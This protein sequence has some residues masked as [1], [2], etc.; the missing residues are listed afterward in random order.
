MPLYN[1]AKRHRRDWAGGTY[2]VML[3]TSSYT[4]NVDHDFVAD[5]VANEATGS[6]YTRQDLANKSASIDDTNNRADHDA[7]NVTWASLTSSFRYAV[8]FFV[9][10]SDADH[11]L[12]LYEDLG[13]QS[14]TAAP[15]TIAW[16]NGA[17]SGTVYRGT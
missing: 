8:V 14:L 15:F 10:S 13:A 5:I 3:L 2:R 12:L 16:N 17:T 9:V 4:P 6:G 7:D 11:E 1:I